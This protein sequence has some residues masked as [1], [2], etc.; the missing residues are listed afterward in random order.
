MTSSRPRTS[1]L[2]AARLAGTQTTTDVTQ[3][4]RIVDSPEQPIAPEP[5]RK[6]DALTLMMF[7]ALGT[8]VSAAALVVGTLMDHSVRYGEEIEA[9]LNVPVLATVPNSPGAFPTRVL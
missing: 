9:N 7:L 5:H 8:L 4:L 3:R 6:K 1:S 2:A